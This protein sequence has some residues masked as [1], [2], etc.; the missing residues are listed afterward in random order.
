MTQAE[1][2]TMDE[3]RR[4]DKDLLT[5]QD[6]SGVLRADPQTIRL[7]A[8]EHPELVGYPFTFHGNAMKIPRSGFINWFDGKR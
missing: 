5:P 8:R 7:S 3:I 2:L 1:K 4:S 6:I